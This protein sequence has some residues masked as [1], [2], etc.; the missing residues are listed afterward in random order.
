M[1]ERYSRIAEHTLNTSLKEFQSTT[2][3]LYSTHAGLAKFTQTVSNAIHLGEFLLQSG[4]LV[5]AKIVVEQALDISQKGYFGQGAAL[6]TFLLGKIH[7]FQGDED[8]ARQLFDR[9]IKL[10][11]E[12]VGEV[13]ADVARAFNN[14]GSLLGDRGMYTEA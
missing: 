4:L 13:H 1:E 5:G 10:Q 3:T 9:A 7:H 2:P 6:A 12:Q 14:L 11:V 8:S